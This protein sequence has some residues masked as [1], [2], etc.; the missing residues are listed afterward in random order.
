MVPMTV[1]RLAVDLC[2]LTTE[3]AAGVAA[4]ADLQTVVAHHDFPYDP[5]PSRRNLLAQLAY[6]FPG[7][8]SEHWLAY[9]AGVLVGLVD[10]ELPTLDNLENAAVEVLVHPAHRASGVGRQLADHALARTRANGRRRAIIEICENGPGVPPE[11]RTGMLL[12][13]SFG[14]GRALA[15]VRR[16]LD[17]TTVESRAVERQLDQAA[18]ASPGYHLVS[19][20]DVVPDAAIE[21]VATL[22]S[23]MV[24][25]SPMGDLAWEPEL[26]DAKRWRGMEA[27]L[28]GRGHR[29]YG[30]ASVHT[31]TGTVAGYT[32]CTVAADVPEY[33]DQWS[34]IVLPEHRGHRLGLRLKTSN[35]LRLLEL[36][37]A[38]RM[39]DTWNAADNSHMIAV[40]ESLGFRALDTWAEWQ[41]ELP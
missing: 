6:P 4:R 18:A 34:T 40:N 8:D 9:A 25:D 38:A 39:I 26:H 41:L 10:V 36:E 23:R 37:P 30:C 31:D 33:V 28:T 19:W 21:G 29:S 13:R 3:D 17:L 27:V 32:M 24:T 12:A 20:V 35:Q 2:L 5:G 16:R 7:S 1:G 15:D 22:E 14:A 11:D